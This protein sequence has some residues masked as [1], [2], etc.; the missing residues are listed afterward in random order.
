MDVK[1]CKMCKRLFNYIAGVPI[2]PACKEELENKF[3]QAKEYVRS[4]KS[5]TVQMVANEIGV[6]ESQVQEWIRDERLV[7]SEASIA[8][9]AC[10]V[11]GTPINTG[12]YCEQ[13]KAQMLRDLNGVIKK[14]EPP[15]KQIIRDNNPRMRFLDNR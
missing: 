1:S 11:C 9:V 10:E 7:F 13:C 5:A 6:P 15:K 12:R 4:N 2:C 8:G 14:P 3:Q